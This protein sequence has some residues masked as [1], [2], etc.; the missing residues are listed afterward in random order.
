MGNE[1]QAKPVPTYKTTAEILRSD[2]AEIV[3]FLRRAEAR[4]AI[5]QARLKALRAEEGTYE[6]AEEYEDVEP[7]AQDLSKL[8]NE[9]LNE[10]VEVLTEQI[11]Q[12]EQRIETNRRAVNLGLLRKANRAP[13]CSRLKKGGEPCRA[14]AVKGQSLCYFHNVAADTTRHPE[15]QID[16][17]EDRESMQVTLKQIMEHVVSKRMKPSDAGVLLRAIQIANCVLKPQKPTVELAKR[18][19]PHRETGEDSGVN[20]QE[21][22]G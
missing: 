8:S 4:L 2:P 19:P 21:G 10:R 3:D 7:S 14:P 18:K 13:R 16:V 20:P 22:R 6:W 1:E 11:Q 9:M 15:V 5:S 17:L 12:T